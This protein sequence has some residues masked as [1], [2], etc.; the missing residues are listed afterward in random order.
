MS[1]AERP[2][3]RPVVCAIAGID[4]SGHA[5]L[6]ADLRTLADLSCHGTAITTS[7]TLQNAR[8]C[9]A[10]APLLQPGLQSQ[11]QCLAEDALPSA[12]KVG[13]CQ[14]DGQRA[15]LRA[16]Q[17]RHP[18][19]HWVQDPVA[20]AS[21]AGATLGRAWLLPG[22]IL[23]PNLPELASLLGRA[24]RTPA[25]ITRAAQD[26][27]ALG[28]RA[29]WV[30][31]GHSESLQWVDDYFCS[32][33]QRFWL[34]RPR[35]QAQHT[36]GTGC[37]LSAALAAFLAQ[38]KALADAV[39]LASAYVHQAL[40]LG[41]APAGYPIDS[42]GPLGQGGWPSSLDDFPLLYDREPA[43]TTPF[44]PAPALG[45]YVIVDSVDWLARVLKA[46][47]K[48]AQLRIKNLQG[49]ALNRAIADAIALGRA[50]QAQVFI[51][52]YWQR[53][54]ALGAWGVHLG[55][56]DLQGANLDA[57]ARAGVR[58]GISAHS[59]AEWCRALACAPSYV[60]LGAAFSSH[61]KAV[62]VIPAAELQRWLEAL[63][64]RLPVVVIG[65]INADTLP[66]LVA[67]GV[68]HAAVISAV[69]GAQNPEAAVQHLSAL[70]AHPK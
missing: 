7:I 50:Y 23:T 70:L 40:R 31:G 66:G 45:L 52:D 48:T 53:A 22:S 24:V 63:Q 20:S 11:W 28:A 38:G 41:Y 51:N 9:R 55:Q 59:E 54:L 4:P 1:P 32:P 42:A 13:L 16:L 30:K 47:V 67:M 5:G 14:D 64:S 3:T 26:C 10:A 68:R 6:L 56:E 34:R 19:L 29:V 15:Q 39:V 35:L 37:V 12:I 21:Q 8:A 69:T 36:R 62:P 25:E 65:G 27:L 61:T 33:T 18:Q 2:G 57:L 43:P 44:P 46:G 60:A 49:P 58:L 17:A